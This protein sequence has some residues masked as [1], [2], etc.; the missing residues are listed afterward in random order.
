ML[1]IAVPIENVQEIWPTKMDFG[2]PNAEIGRKMANGRLL[3]LA[4]VVTLEL[5][6]S[7]TG[8]LHNCMDQLQ[9]YKTHMEHSWLQTTSIYNRW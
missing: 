7:V 4:L 5:L 3:F 2:W 1:L 8:P 6:H 9:Q